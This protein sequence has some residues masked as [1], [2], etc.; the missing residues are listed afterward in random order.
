MCSGIFGSTAVT[1]NPPVKR[2]ERKK[3]KNVF[4]IHDSTAFL[5][6]FMQENGKKKKK[7]WTDKTGDLA[8]ENCWF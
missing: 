2:E 7:D 1:A 6:T 4:Y 5:C 8:E 3:R